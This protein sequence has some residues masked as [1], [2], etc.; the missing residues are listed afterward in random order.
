MKKVALKGGFF[1]GS[2]D[3][4]KDKDASRTTNAITEHTTLLRSPAHLLFFHAIVV[5]SLSS[6]SGADWLLLSPTKPQCPP[7][8]KAGP[9]E[10]HAYLSSFGVDETR[11][12]CHIVSSRLRDSPDRPI[13]RVF[14]QEDDTL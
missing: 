2:V 3:Q 12:G 14:R 7:V 13:V 11:V 8:D 1:H 6:W 4:V 5:K 10:P 9:A